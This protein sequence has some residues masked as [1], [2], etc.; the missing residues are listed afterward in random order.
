MK[1]TNREHN[2]GMGWLSLAVA[3]TAAG[4]LAYAHVSRAQTTVE[5]CPLSQGYWKNHAEAW[6]RR[7]LVLGSFTRSEHTYPQSALLALLDESSKGDV[8]L[9]LARQLIA[10]KLNVANGTNPGPISASLADADA[11]LATFTGKQT[12]KIRQTV[13]VRQEFSR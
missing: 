3:I 8:S 4:V 6:P 7:V 9:I 1:G 10:A 11:L 5:A 2:S 13:H 12:E